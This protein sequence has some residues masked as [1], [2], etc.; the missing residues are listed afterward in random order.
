MEWY[1]IV[2]PLEFIQTGNFYFNSY[3]IIWNYPIHLA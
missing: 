1:G 2:T 3:F